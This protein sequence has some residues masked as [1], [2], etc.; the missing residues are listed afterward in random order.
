MKL[1]THLNLIMTSECLELCSVGQLLL[2]ISTFMFTFKF[3]TCRAYNFNNIEVIYYITFNRIAGKMASS[4][5]GRLFFRSRK[6]S[7]ICF[8]YVEICFGAHSSS[9]PVSTQCSFVRIKQ[10]GRNLSSYL[11]PM[12]GALPPLLLFAFVVCFLGKE[13]TLYLS[14]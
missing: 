11:V 14:Y 4:R 8:H 2:L 5:H 1:A 3:V 7:N 9:Y 12:R 13:T 10:R 6:R